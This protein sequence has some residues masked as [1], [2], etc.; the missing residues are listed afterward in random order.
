MIFLI[1]SS[2]IFT[3]VLA[4]VVQSVISRK[5]KP[6]N[7]VDE[8]EIPSFGPE[9]FF[10]HIKNSLPRGMGLIY[11]VRSEIYDSTDDRYTPWPVDVDGDFIVHVNIINPITNQVMGS[12][13]LNERRLS[14]EKAGDIVQDAVSAALKQIEIKRIAGIREIII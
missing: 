6:E 13:M 8:I 10:N 11:D 9:S 5:K 3:I 1:I 14:K 2:V 7:Q 4:S 12:M